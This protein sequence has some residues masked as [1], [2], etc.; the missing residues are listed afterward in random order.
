MSETRRS[1]PNDSPRRR[2]SVEGCDAM[3]AIECEMCGEHV[4]GK[5]S[6]TVLMMAL[7]FSC[8]I[9]L[10]EGMTTEGGQP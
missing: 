3:A 9:G 4:C 1:H 6:R 10:S 8:G 2:C 7:C 5:H